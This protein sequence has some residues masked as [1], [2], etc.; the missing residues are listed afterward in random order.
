MSGLQIRSHADGETQDR[1]QF[2]PGETRR[3]PGIGGRAGRITQAVE[4]KD[5][6]DRFCRTP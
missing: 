3:V 2:K 5:E 4:Q 1:R 6:A